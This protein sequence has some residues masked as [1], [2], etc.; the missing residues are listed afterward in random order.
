MRSMRSSLPF[1]LVGS[2]LALIAAL[3]V[4]PRNRSERASNEPLPE[5]S[6]A[7]SVASAAVAAPTSSAPASEDEASSLKPKLDVPADA[8]EIYAFQ[9]QAPIYSAAEYPPHEAK[10]DAKHMPLG[11]FRLGYLRRGEHVFA[12]KGTVGGGSCAEGWYQLLQGGFVCGKFVTTNIHHRDLKFAPHGPELEKPLPYDYGLVISAGTPAYRRIPSKAERAEVE[13]TLAKGR[14]KKAADIVKGMKERGEELPAYL[15]DADEK[16]KSRATFKDLGS[17]SELVA[18]RMLK[19][20]YLSLDKKIAGKS[21]PMWHTMNGFLTPS[22]HILLHES[23]T[24]F[25]GVKL[26]DPNEKRHLPL[27]FVVGTK[28][29]E[30]T[31]D[32]EHTET[33]IDRFTISQLTG[34]KHRVGKHLYWEAEGG[35][36]LQDEEIAVVEKPEEMPKDIVPGEK[37]IDVDLSG[38]ALIAYEGEKPVYATIVSTGRHSADPEH[39]HRTVVGD[40]RIREKHITTTMDDDASSDGTYRIDDVPWVMYFEKSFALHGAFWH[41][42]FGR[43]RSHGCVNLTP[44]DARNLFAWSGP[45]VPD[46]WHGVRATKENPGT[47]VVVHK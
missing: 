27:A 16:Q 7:T 43:E 14:G 20:F 34:Q 35:K 9:Q 12:K 10:E 31:K 28:A 11:V 1:V 17:E 33:K 44:F 32:G 42:S 13:K 15:K 25:E 23:K 36:W 46:G 22:D 47:R 8:V 19:G 29:H 21:G 45:H 4:E 26:G 30:W 39:D 37:W 24:E 6:A 40:F 5:P 38:E 2:S 3:V 41:S 18:Q